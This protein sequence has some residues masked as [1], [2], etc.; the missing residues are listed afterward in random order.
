M[1]KDA[2]CIKPSRVEYDACAEDVTCEFQYDFKTQ[3]PVAVLFKMDSR[4]DNDRMFDRE[5]GHFFV[6]EDSDKIISTGW[7]TY[8]LGILCYEKLNNLESYG[9]KFPMQFSSN[10]YYKNYPQRDDDVDYIGTEILDDIRNSI[11][12]VVSAE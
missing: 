3:R 10:D 2:L 11:E 8:T 12:L 4:L 7:K 9:G 5:C 1:D 6:L